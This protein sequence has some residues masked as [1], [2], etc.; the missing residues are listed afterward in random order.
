M[1]DRPRRVGPDGRAS[2]SPNAAPTS[3]PSTP[4]ASPRGAAGRNGGFLLAGLALFH[5]DAVARTAV[6]GRCAL[7]RWTLEELDRTLAG[8]PDD[9]V[10]RVGALRIAAGDDEARRLRAHAAAMPPTICRPRRTTVPRGWACSSRPTP[11]W[12]RTPAAPCSPSVRRPRGARL[13]APFRRRPRS[14]RRRP[15]RGRRGLRADGS[16][17]PSTAGSRRCCP[18]SPHGCAASRLQMVATAPD[19]GCACPG[20]STAAGATT[21]PSRCPR[22]RSCSAGS[23]TAVC[24]DEGAPPVPSDGRAGPPRRASCAGSG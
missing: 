24:D 6:S 23:A 17:S 12:T 21:T 16:S 7:Y 3:W 1:R 5:H 2:T 4:T 19:A 20:R 11:R 10:R 18:N 9:V 8:L 22:A 15:R 13:H 14:T